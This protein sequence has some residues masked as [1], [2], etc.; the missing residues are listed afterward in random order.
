MS[1]TYLFI[2]TLVAVQAALLS[3]GLIESGASSIT[4][5]RIHFIT[6]GIMT[7]LIFGYIP[8]YIS[9]STISVRW[10]V[11]LTLN[12]G[13]IL[14]FYGRA[15]LDS[16]LMITGG[17]LIFTATSLFMF[18]INSLK[19]EDKGY[20]TH[21]FYVI[22]SIFLLTGI[23]IGTGIWA[24]WSEPLGIFNALEAHIHAQNWGFLSLVF[25]GLLMDLYPKFANKEIAN[26]ESINR[27]LILLTM[28]GFT[29]VLSPWL[30]G[31]FAIPIAVFG[32]LVFIIG[33]I[34]LLQNMIRPMDNIR[35]NIGF[36][37][38]IGGYSWIFM[39]LVFAPFVLLKIPGFNHV[40]ANAPQALV[41]GW[42]L[43]I[44]IAILPFILG[45]LFAPEKAKLGGNKISFITVNLGS[46]F[47]WIGIFIIDSSPVLHGIA[48]SLWFISFIP[49]LRDSY[50]IFQ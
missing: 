48:Y 10:D 9:K 26:P 33:T 34:M 38:I 31:S 30:G 32:M 11:F 37:H 49:A 2:G 42:I 43:Q 39:P 22:A 17:T 16:V 44:L 40:E 25:A 3:F 45:L 50:N 5:V 13:F 27:I 29:L 46:I 18:Q 21:M 6:L 4:W 7:Q 20:S 23:I 36:M 12:S 24:G 41:Y 8:S 47:L 28:G 14:F 35:E 1:F 15:I 19:S